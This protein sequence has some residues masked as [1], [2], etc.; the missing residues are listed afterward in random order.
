MWQR[1]TFAIPHDATPVTCSQVA[2]HPWDAEYGHSTPDGSYLNPVNAIAALSGKL[3][4]ASAGH[5]VVILLVCAGSATEFAQ[6]LAGLSAVLP[7]PALQQTARRARTQI[8]QATERMIIPAT[9][10]D[11]IPA[12]APLNISTLSDTLNR[13]ASAA[14]MN[15][16]GVADMGDIKGALAAFRQH[17][18]QLIQQAAESIKNPPKAAQ[19]WAFVARGDVVRAGVDMLKNIPSPSSSMT[20]VHMFTG[21]LSSMMNWITEG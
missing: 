11:G 16:P 21:D 18:E 14:A 2:I 13:S 9:P 1:V 6:Q 7:L 17:R 12:P 20:Y 8:S 4:K 3:S 10:V 5:D 15:A 19:I